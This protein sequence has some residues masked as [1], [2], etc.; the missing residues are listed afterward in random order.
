[1]RHANT[2]TPTIEEQLSSSVP[3]PA[4][5]KTDAGV[6]RAGLARRDYVLL[7]LLSLFTVLAMFAAA[8]CATRLI[9]REG[10]R[11]VCSS[12]DP[13]TGYREKPNCTAVMKIPES[14]WVA[15][16]FNNC[17]YRTAAACGPKPAGTI[18]VALLG[19]SIAE[20]YMVPYAD[21]FAAQA[22]DLLSR[23]C[24]RRV[25]FQNLAAEGSEPIYAYHRL[26]EALGLQPN[27]VLFAINP[28]DVEQHIDRKLLASRNSGRPMK[29]VSSAP[30]VKENAVQKI[31]DLLH[32]SRTMI[33]AQHFMLQDRDLSLRL[34]AAAGG[35]HTAFLDV[36]FPEAW[37]KR[38]ADIDVLLGDMAAKTRVA[39]VPLVLLGIPERAEA[40]M[41]N[42][43]D[44]PAGVDPNAF[45]RKLSQ[46]A[47]QHGIVYLDVFDDF[48]RA[49]H[50]EQLF[51][52]VDGHLGPEGHVLVG[53]AIARAFVQAGIPAFSS[54]RAE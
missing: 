5:E 27:A 6:E 1:M 41:L 8:E 30:A 49:D 7:P 14:G 33:V 26:N 31:E 19:S 9:W 24:H 53:R 35:D 40:A 39:G 28:Y 3:D 50:V 43:P 42:A 37:Q 13:L 46:M 34:Y 47:A 20:G 45:D 52:P 16:T 29:R 18:R 21:T 15:H 51:Y 38:F 48:K 2:G 4:A 44:L 12:Y 32:Q 25:E 22:S 10:G 36:P 11:D 54:C 23:Y 17:G